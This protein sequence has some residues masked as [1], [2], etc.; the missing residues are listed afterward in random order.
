MNAGLRLEFSDEKNQT[1]KQ[2]YEIFGSPIEK[3]KPNILLPSLNPLLFMANNLQ[4]RCTQWNEPMGVEGQ[5]G[6]E[7][8]DGSSRVSLYIDIDE[9]AE[10]KFVLD[11]MLMLE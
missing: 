3:K 10:F 5:G 11:G 9:F 6:R 1:K 4:K 7:G 8:R 2:P